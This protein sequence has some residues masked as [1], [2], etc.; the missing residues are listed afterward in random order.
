[1]PSLES[2]HE[3]ADTRLLLQL[4][5]LHLITFRWLCCSQIQ[6]LQSSVWTCTVLWHATNF[7]FALEW[8]TEESTYSYPWDSVSHF[9]THNICK[10]LL[11]TRHTRIDMMWQHKCTEW[12][13]EEDCS[14]ETAEGRGSPEDH[15]PTGRCHSSYWGHCPRMRKV[16]V[17]SVRHFES[18]RQHC[19]WDALLHVLPK[20]E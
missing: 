7:G 6:M 4:T 20:A 10:A 14:Q 15:F 2:D 19:R 1:M 8:R 16:H 3:E 5:M 12:Y 9:S 18:R 17:L 13:W 11:A